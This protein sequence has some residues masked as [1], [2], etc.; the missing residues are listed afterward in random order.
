MSARE[1]PPSV[2]PKP[3][4]SGQ[5]GKLLMGFLNIFPGCLNVRY[6]RVPRPPCGNSSRLKTSFQVVSRYT[7]TSKY[8]AAIESG[9]GRQT[10][11]HARL[12][13]SKNLALV[14]EIASY[15]CMYRHVH[16]AP[17]L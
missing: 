9:R 4:S 11:Q 5:I 10:F 12:K 6:L 13:T 14:G 17:D 3:F 7:C 16:D 1:E 8:L 15:C 2:E